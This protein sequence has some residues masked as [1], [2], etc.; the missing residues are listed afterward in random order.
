MRI[1]AI[2]PGNEQ[3]GYVLCEHG[4]DFKILDF[5]KIDNDDIFP[6]IQ[7]KADFVVIE[8]VASYGMPVGREVFE[9]V[10]W[11]GRFYEEADGRS[12][13]PFRVFRKDIKLHFCNSVRAKDANI[14]QAL[15]DRFGGKEKAI[16]NKKSPGILYGLK[17]DA[18]SALAVAL[19]FIVCN[20]TDF[21]FRAI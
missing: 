17:A 21:C 13:N 6:L 10:F 19:Y 18:W 2:D 7:E 8:M 11:I 3:S 12:S 20:E 5:G 14:R 1:L 4:E 15:I 16:G 9:T